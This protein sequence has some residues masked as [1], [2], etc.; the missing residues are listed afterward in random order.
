MSFFLAVESLDL[1]RAAI[2]QVLKDEGFQLPTAPARNAIISAERML[3]WMD[4]NKDKA[5]VIASSLV[6]DLDKCFPKSKSPNAA[7]D[8]LWTNFFQLRSS[9]DF[10]TFWEKAV[11]ESTGGEACPIFYQFVVDHMMK[12]L[13]T[14]RFPIITPEK[15]SVT[16]EKILDFE[17]LCALRYTAGSVIRSLKKKIK[18]SAHPQKT[19]I[20]LCLTEM[21]E[22]SGSYDKL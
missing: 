6:S 5:R 4:D 12:Q 14:V 1:F 16:I 11:S 18:K 3:E 13:V 21:V 19:E 9:S 7:R 8:K 20:L 10:R 15:E 22:Q 17:D 2:S